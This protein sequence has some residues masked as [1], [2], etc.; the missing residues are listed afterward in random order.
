MVVVA[1]MLLLDKYLAC[2]ECGDVFIFSAGEQELQRLRGIYSLP[3]LCSVCARRP[4]TVASRPRRVEHAQVS[5][6]A[7]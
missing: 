4:W 6:Q 2:S 5:R 3:N 1:R 7:A